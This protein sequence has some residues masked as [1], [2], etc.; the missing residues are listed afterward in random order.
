M[1]GSSDKYHALKGIDDRHPRPV[2]PQPQDGRMT[3]GL[4]YKLSLEQLA[5]NASDITQRFLPKRE[6]PS[7][8]A[9]GTKLHAVGGAPGPAIA[10]P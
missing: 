6:P 3:A 1:T 4:Y 2:K 5:V 7:P 8:T 10:E 9:V